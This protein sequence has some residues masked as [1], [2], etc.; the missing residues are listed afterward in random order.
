MS[1]GT[2]HDQVRYGSYLKV[3]ELLELQ[4]PFT[5]EHDEMQFIV[6]HQ[7]YELWFRLVLHEL[8]AVMRLLETA[9]GKTRARDE[10]LWEAKRLLE[11]VTKIQDVLVLHLPILETMRP[12]DFLRFRDRLKPASGFQSA[13]F[14]E[15][16]FLAGQKDR[17][18]F[19]RCDADPKSMERLAAR[20]DGPTLRERFA[21]VARSR[22]L[23]VVVG[24][25]GSAEFARAVSALAALYEKPVA[26]P[27]L[28]ALAEG[29]CDFD[30]RLALWRSRHLAMV[31]RVIGGKLGTGY[32]ATGAG[33]E[34][35]RYL[36]GTL[37]KRAFPELWEVRTRMGEPS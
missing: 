29:F 24:E 22:G 13:Q 34:G 18:L 35:M 3:P 10:D 30:E 23:E 21:D 25:P 14:R 32:A 12:G 11:R 17:A 37:R 15:V 5:E 1:F 27:A 20:L 28:Y 16:E 2:P 36:A 26:D 8:D 31:E 19:E 7:V 6:V 9:D 33:Y 4:N